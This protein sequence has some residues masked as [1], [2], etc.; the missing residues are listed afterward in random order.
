LWED[1]D[2]EAEKAAQAPPSEDDA[3]RLKSEYLDVIISD[4]RAKDNFSFSVQILNTEGEHHTE[5]CGW[6]CFEHFCQALRRWKS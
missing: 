5:L 4:V 6:S 2:E 1:Y 3:G